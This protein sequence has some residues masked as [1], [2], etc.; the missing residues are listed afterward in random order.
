MQTHPA[1]N[2]VA[3]PLQRIEQE[4]QTQRHLLA[5][6]SLRFVRW[7]SA[8]DQRQQAIDTSLAQLTARLQTSERAPMPHQTLK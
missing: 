7:Q 2:G 1:E 3:D 4:F 6:E 8:W 5:E